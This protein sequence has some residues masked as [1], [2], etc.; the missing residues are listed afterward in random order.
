MP[1]EKE[2]QQRNPGLIILLI[3]DS[4]SMLECLAGT[5]EPRYKWTERYAGHI[6]KEL[7]DLSSDMKGDQLIVKPRYYISVIKYGSTTELW[8]NSIMTIE[9]AVK[10]Y[11]SSGNSLEL[12]G[13]LRGTDANLAFEEAYEEL[14]TA[15]NKER[16]LD[17][18]P[19]MI[20]HLT[21]GE[22]QTDARRTVDK[23][24]QLSTSDGN[25]LV[26]NAYIGTQTSLNYNGPKDF[27]GYVDADEAG[28]SQDNLHLF[29][30]SSVAPECIE[31]NLKADDV[32]PK[33]R[34]GSR[35]FFDVR[36]KE[37]LKSVFQVIGSMQT[38]TVT[39]S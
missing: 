15:L 20:L 2:I 37:M 1:Y 39:Q 6:F 36:T 11:S 14:Q 22:S 17:S 23:I 19:P 12:G 34:S 31:R 27:P 13:N 32:F 18:F 24:K 7:L 30:M 3:D 16:F 5:S 9:E 33:L 4:C 25:V 8:G 28:P 35:L 29:E 10:L 38:K 21:D 26:V